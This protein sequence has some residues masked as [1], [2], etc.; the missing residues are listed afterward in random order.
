MYTHLVAFHLQMLHPNRAL[1]NARLFYELA[2]LPRSMHIAFSL[3]A[4]N[5]KRYDV[6]KNAANGNNVVLIAKGV[7]GSTRAC[8]LFLDFHTLLLHPLA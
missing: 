1:F 3:Y 6:Q 7:K 4:I 5:R 2:C 8:G